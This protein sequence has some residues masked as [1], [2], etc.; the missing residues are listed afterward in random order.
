[1]EAGVTEA[2]LT[3]DFFDRQAGFGL[4]QKSN[5]LLFAVFA[6]FACPSLSIVMDFLE[7]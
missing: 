6:W 7:K 1:M 4:S 2:V 5:G 3:P